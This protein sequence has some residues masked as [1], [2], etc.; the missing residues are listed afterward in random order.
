MTIKKF[1]FLS[2]SCN[3]WFQHSSRWFSSVFASACLNA[4]CQLTATEMY[5]I[6]TEQTRANL[7]LKQD[8]AVVS[9]TT[10][11]IISVYFSEMALHKTYFFTEIL[12]LTRLFTI[13]FSRGA[14]KFWQKHKV[15]F[16]PY[17]FLWDMAY[18]FLYVLFISV[19]TVET[20]NRNVFASCFVLLL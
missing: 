9:V 1:L 11:I 17:L 18:S 14:S 6:Y 7:T 12:W 19:L 15:I 2:F 16:W 5:I 3:A 10:H 8:S 20:K 13:L 4:D